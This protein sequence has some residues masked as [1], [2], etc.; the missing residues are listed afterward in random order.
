MARNKPPYRPAE[1]KT[2]AGP[3]HT[4]L[5]GIIERVSD[6]FVALDRDWRYVYVRN[7]P[8]VLRLSPKTP[9]TGV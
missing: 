3:S 4:L 5:E 2:G 9:V 7:A 8:P 6:G 1:Q